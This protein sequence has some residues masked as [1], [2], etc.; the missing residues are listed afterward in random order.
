VLPGAG[1][2]GDR[3]DLLRTAGELDQLGQHPAPGDVKRD[4]DAVGRERANPPGQAVAVGDR[5]GPQ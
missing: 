1:E 2:V 3:H 5:L 4:V